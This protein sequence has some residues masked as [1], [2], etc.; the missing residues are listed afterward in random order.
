MFSKISNTTCTPYLLITVNDFLSPFMVHPY[1]T[2]YDK[3]NRLYFT[4]GTIIKF[5]IRS[6]LTTLPLLLHLRTCIFPTYFAA[7]LSPLALVILSIAFPFRIILILAL[8]YVD[9]H[10]TPLLVIITF[11]SLISFRSPVNSK[12]LIIPTATHMY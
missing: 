9:S 8:C 3:L 11:L 4:S 1:F 10:V 6:S 5:L 2:L 12:I 7:M